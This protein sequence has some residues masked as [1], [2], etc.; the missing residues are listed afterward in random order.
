MLRIPDFC[1]LDGDCITVHPKTIDPFQA[2]SVKID[3]QAERPGF[4]TFTPQVRYMGDAKK[5]AKYE[6]SPVVIGFSAPLVDLKEEQS[7]DASADLT[8]EFH[9][10][11]TRSAF[12]YLMQSF[13]QDFLRQKM[14]LDVAGWR[15]LMDIV[16]NTKITKHSLYEFSRSKGKPISEL[17][18]LGLVE[19]KYFIGQRGRGGRVLK[20]RASYDNQT[21]RAQIKRL[22]AK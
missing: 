6:L 11:L 3:L 13:V 16:K 7:I 2:I 1:S 22:T 20:V 19:S 8:I 14:P 5:I 4:F 17:E 12:Q 15:S 9:N 21:V 18:R 10:E